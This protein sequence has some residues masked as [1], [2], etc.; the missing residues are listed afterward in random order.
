[1][2]KHGTS[3][4]EGEGDARGSRRRVPA[5][6]WGPARSA[7]A[8]G[9]RGA[10]AGVVEERGDTE[11]RDVSTVPLAPGGE[12]RGSQGHTGAG[13]RKGTAGWGGEEGMGRPEQLPHAGVNTAGGGCR[14]GREVDGGHEVVWL[15]FLQSGPH[16]HV[17]AP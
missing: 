3:V 11:G 13:R 5:G 1:M 10:G 8:G 6:G 9:L 2:G 17:T 4:T 7:T 16:A 12:Q 15:A 14:E